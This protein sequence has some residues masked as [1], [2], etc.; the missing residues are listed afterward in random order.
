MDSQLLVENRDFCLPTCIRHPCYEGPRPDI[1]ITV[2]MQKLEWFGYQMVKK[3]LRTQLI[4]LTEFTNLS[5]GETDGRTDGWAPHDGIGRA[6][7]A[8]RGKT[9]ST[10]GVKND[11]YGRSPNLPSASCDA[12]RLSVVSFNSTIRRAQSSVISYFRFRFIAA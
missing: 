2:S 1:A 4:V 8:S 12:S 10:K 11:A 3:S 9:Y 7:I 5:D 6:C